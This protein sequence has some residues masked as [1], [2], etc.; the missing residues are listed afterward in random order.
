MNIIKI[1]LTGQ[2]D[3]LAIDLTKKQAN[4]Y[5]YF[6]KPWSETDFLKNIKS[7]LSQL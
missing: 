2:V 6:S 7:G 3:E 4:I 1:L 5:K